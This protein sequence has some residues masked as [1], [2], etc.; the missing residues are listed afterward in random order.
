MLTE[1][2]RTDDRYEDVKQVMTDLN[3]RLE[4]RV[5]EHPEQY[6]WL[7]RRWKKLGIHAPRPKKEK[8]S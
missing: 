1:P 7:H 2:P 5:R 4:E 8:Q 6:F 3:R